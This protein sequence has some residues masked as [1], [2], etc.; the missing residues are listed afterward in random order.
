MLCYDAKILRFG[1]KMR[2]K[3]FFVLLLVVFSVNVYAVNITYFSII[4]VSSFTIIAK[5]HEAQK[6][7]QL[8]PGDVKDIAM[9]SHSRMSEPSFQ[10]FDKLGRLHKLEGCDLQHSSSSILIEIIDKDGGAR[11]SLLS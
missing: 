7:R 10:Y 4:N 8:E 3:R 6:A 1:G 5:V 9:A 11:C 2:F